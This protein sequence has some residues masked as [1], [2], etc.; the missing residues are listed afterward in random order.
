MSEYAF[1]DTNLFL[2]YFLNDIP[3]QADAVEAIFT[4]AR[5]GNLELITN[6]LIIAEVVWVLESFYQLEREMIR[7]CVLSI[8][9]TPNLRVSSAN[10]ITQAIDVYVSKNI[11]FID[12]FSTSWMQINHIKAAYTF[13][14]KHFSRVAGIEVRVPE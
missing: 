5:T 2:R 1:V 4:Q 6:E 12:A 3:A 13:D 10:I 8:L 7:K 11:D 9:N 14:K